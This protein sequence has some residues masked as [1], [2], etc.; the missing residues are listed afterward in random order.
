MWFMTKLIAAL[1]YFF[2]IVTVQ[3]HAQEGASPGGGE[4]SADSAESKREF[5]Q[6]LDDFE[7]N[8]SKDVPPTKPAAKPSAPKVEKT[9]KAP[10][11][12]AKAVKTAKS[13][14]AA[15]AAKMKK[16]SDKKKPKKKTTPKT[17][18]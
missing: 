8:I 13:K 12:K 14:K 9:E 6:D 10:P 1:V 4:P 15:A 7:K 17:E 2:A 3:A 5:T 11:A 18:S 16:K